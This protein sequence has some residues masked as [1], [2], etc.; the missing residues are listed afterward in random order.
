MRN[1]LN[2]LNES[3][4]IAGFYSNNLD[5]GLG[6]FLKK[7]VDKV[8][9]IGSAVKTYMLSKADAIAAW[10]DKNIFEPLKAYITKLVPGYAWGSNKTNDS[11]IIESVIS[12]L[13]KQNNQVLE[14]SS[15][16]YSDRKADRISE[17]VKEYVKSV[18]T[19]FI[20]ERREP[21][22]E[23][24]AIGAV[25]SV[26]HWSHFAV[27]VLEAIL[28]VAPSIPFLAGLINKLNSAQAFIKNNPKLAK[29]VDWYEHGKIGS[30]PAKDVINSICIAVGIVEICMGGGVWIILST[31]ASAAWVI[32]EKIW[33]HYKAADKDAS[34]VQESF[35]GRRISRE[36]SRRN[37][38][39]FI[40][41]DEFDDE[42]EGVHNED[43]DEYEDEEDFVDPIYDGDLEDDDNFDDDE[44][45]DF[46]D[47]TEFDEIDLDEE[48]DFV[49]P[50]GRD[51]EDDE[52]DEY[53]HNSEDVDIDDDD[54]YCDPEDEDCD[55]EDEDFDDDSDSDIDDEIHSDVEE[56]EIE[57]GCSMKESITARIRR[58]E[59]RLSYSR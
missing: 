40:E 10:S 42:P 51:L 26:I 5:E 29:A 45:D 49:G 47:P 22:T 52:D 14:S 21:I 39:R 19:S 50:T 38:S 16:K 46:E 2:V 4:I 41:E 58:L 6:D 25:L 43:E 15:S 9:E 57:E 53:E 32:M 37:E 27:D 36:R 1:N 56:D 34:K 3:A 20:R 55:I 28:K 44:I 17:G 33:H 7:A 31:A 35:T 24:G 13:A 48:D 12:I 59:R 23:A 18:K 54:D 8:K 11:G 30:L